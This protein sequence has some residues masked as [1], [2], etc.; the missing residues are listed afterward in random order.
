MGNLK[1]CTE[2]SLNGPTPDYV[3]QTLGQIIYRAEPS[4]LTVIVLYLPV[5]APKSRGGASIASWE[6]LLVP[7][8][9]CE[10]IACFDKLRINTSAVIHHLSVTLILVLII[11]EDT[12]RRR[13]G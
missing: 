5:P 9:V 11:D 6:Y 12:S 2:T 7:F 10:S 3:T 8:S 4:K 1:T 13:I